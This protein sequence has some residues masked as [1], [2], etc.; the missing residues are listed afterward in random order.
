MC[1]PSYK[2]VT[3]TVTVTNTSIIVKLALPTPRVL[4][5]STTCTVYIGLCEILLPIL[6]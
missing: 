6:I 1:K 2:N 4:T 3:W 5:P